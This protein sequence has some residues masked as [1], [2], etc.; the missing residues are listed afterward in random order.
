MLKFEALLKTCFKKFL[1]R[2]IEKSSPK[3]I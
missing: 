3:I 1:T 2:K